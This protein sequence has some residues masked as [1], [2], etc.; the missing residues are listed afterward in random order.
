MAVQ[1]R[2]S[3]VIAMLVAVQA[4]CPQCGNL[5]C[6]H[7]FVAQTKAGHCCPYCVNDAISTKVVKDKAFYAK[8]ADPVYKKFATGL[9]QSPGNEHCPAC[10]DL[11]CAHGFVAQTKA[12]HCCPYCVNDAISTKVVKDK[13]FYAKHADPVY[14]KF[15]TG[16]TQSPGNEHC[17][18]CGDLVCAHGFVAQAK[19]GHCCPYCVNPAISTEVVKDKAYYAALA[20]PVM[21][22]YR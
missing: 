8:H 19:V 7:G 11:V 6:P 10:G 17:P 12:G 18:A 15:A 21:K 14:K 13:A 22:K 3:V 20:D 16:L 9:T 2:V 4:H 1:M 5:V